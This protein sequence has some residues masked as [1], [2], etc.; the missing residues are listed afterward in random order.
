MAFDDEIRTAI[1]GR[2]V[3]TF[4]YHGRPRM[5]EPHDYGVQKENTRLFGYQIGGASSTRLP[6]W[7]L[8]NIDEIDDLVVSTDTFAGTRSEPGQEHLHWDILFARVQ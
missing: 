7:R 1:A 4:T 8:F 6:A 5:L 2:R 3:V